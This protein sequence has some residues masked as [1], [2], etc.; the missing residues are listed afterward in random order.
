MRMAMVCLMV[1]ALGACTK[2]EEA[3]PPSAPVAAQPPAPDPWP[4][5][6]EGD[7]M[8]NVT[9]SPGAYRVWLLAAKADGCTG[10]LGLADKGLPASGAG[11]ALELVVPAKEALPQCTVRL[12]RQGGAVTVSEDAGC[13]GYHGATCSFAGTAHRVN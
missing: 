8:V 7:V 12:A 1:L 4:G 11:D 13:A 3:P 5:K 2:R 10:D 9:G 6:Y